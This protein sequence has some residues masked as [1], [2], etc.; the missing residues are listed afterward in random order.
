ML[1][2]KI[3]E[4]FTE[5]EES[6]QDES[7]QKHLEKVEKNLKEAAYG[8]VHFTGWNN[9]GPSRVKDKHI[10]NAFLWLKSKMCAPSKAVETEN[11]RAYG[12]SVMV[13]VIIARLV[14]CYFQLLSL[15][16]NNS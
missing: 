15:G 1:I 3:N 16:G 11:V 7:F 4:S 6:I 10:V 13:I 5:D 2:W 8:N 9:P 14:I 12:L